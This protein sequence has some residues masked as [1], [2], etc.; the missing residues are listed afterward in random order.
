MTERAW[1]MWEGHLRKIF[2]AKHHIILSPAHVFLIQAEWYRAGSLQSV[3]EKKEINLKFKECSKIRNYQMDTIGSFL[4]E[5]KR[6]FDL[7]SNTIAW[8]LL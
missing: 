5:E 2:L 1:S 6:V 3:L 8:T 7:A 4:T